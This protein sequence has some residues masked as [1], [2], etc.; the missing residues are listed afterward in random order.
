MR[1]TVI[2]TTMKLRQ[3]S[4]VESS[5][6]FGS[7]E[8]RSGVS[9]QS[10]GKT[11]V[12]CL[13]VSLSST[14]RSQALWEKKKKICKGQMHEGGRFSRAFY[15][16]LNKCCFSGQESVSPGVP[17]SKSHLWQLNTFFDFQQGRSQCHPKKQCTGWA[18]CGNQCCFLQAFSNK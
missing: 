3:I 16:S 7:R 2:R 10:K 9:R 17:R 15:V 18:V 5:I 13:D 1:I 6:F 8:E 11:L 12:T 4:R 14:F